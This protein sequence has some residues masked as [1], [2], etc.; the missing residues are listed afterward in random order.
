MQDICSYIY[1]AGVDGKQLR[2]SP[3]EEDQG[4]CAAIQDVDQYTVSYGNR[5][6][7]ILGGWEFVQ[8]LM[9]FA[10][11]LKFGTPIDSLPIFHKYYSNLYTS[12]DHGL[13]FPK[14]ALFSGHAESLMQ[15]LDGLGL[16]HWQRPNPAS[17]IFFEFYRL[18]TQLYLKMIYYWNDE[19]KKEDVVYLPG[20]TEDLIPFEKFVEYVRERYSDAVFSSLEEECSREYVSSGEFFSGREVVQAMSDLYGLVPPQD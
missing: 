10:E 18:R 15:I 16:H 4:Y 14:F 13:Q 17:A 8:V 6:L 1:W 9:E 5:D 19:E 12:P 3:S 7:E 2:F 11:Y 20:Q